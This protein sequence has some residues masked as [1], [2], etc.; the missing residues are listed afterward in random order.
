MFAIL[1]VVNHIDNDQTAVTPLFRAMENNHL[2]IVKLLVETYGAD[3][4]ECL[5]V[6]I[7]K[8]CLLALICN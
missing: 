8:S 7:H 3:V 1:Q 4:D 6:S 5:N 2:R